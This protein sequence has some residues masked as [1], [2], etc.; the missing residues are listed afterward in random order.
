VSNLVTF[1]SNAYENYDATPTV[2]FSAFT[3]D[4]DNDQVLTQIGN[5]IVSGRPAPMTF[6]GINL[7][8]RA[9]VLEDVEARGV[10]GPRANKGGYREALALEGELVTVS[11]TL[12]DNTPLSETGIITD[13]A[14]RI[15]GGKLGQ[16]I[17]LVFHRVDRVVFLNTDLIL[18]ASQAVEPT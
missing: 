14:V 8:A 12:A 16:S 2:R 7:L 13:L 15:S 1:S 6:R 11:Y 18:S 3:L 5:R 10:A 17:D 9:Q 4:S